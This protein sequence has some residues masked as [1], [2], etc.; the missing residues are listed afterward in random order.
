MS[1]L[2]PLPR[3][4]REPRRAL[5]CLNVRREEK[6]VV[7]HLQSYW[8]LRTG[9][10]LSQCDVFSV[11]LFAALQSGLLEVPAELRGEERVTVG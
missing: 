5:G 6:R 8:E 7:D 4:D 1:L 2:P 11:L 10:Q 9:R 3:T